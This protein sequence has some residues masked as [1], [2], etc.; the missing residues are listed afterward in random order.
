MRRMTSGGQEAPEF[1]VLSKLCLSSM[2]PGWPPDQSVNSYS[3]HDS[4]IF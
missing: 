1:Q 2:K 4:R 3:L